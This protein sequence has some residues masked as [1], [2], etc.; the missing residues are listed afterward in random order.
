M[1]YLYLGRTDD[2]LRL[3]EIGLQ[4]GYLFS[5]VPFVTAVAA[6][7]DRLGVLNTLARQYEDDPQLVRPLFRVLTDHTFNDRDRQNAVALVKRS[8]NSLTF[9]PSALLVLR[10]YGEIASSPSSPPIW[11]ARDDAWLKSQSRKRL[12][13]SWRIVP[14]LR[15]PQLTSSRSPAE[16][17]GRAITGHASAGGEDE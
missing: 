1:T 12:M 14:S 9:V 13:Q 2:A 15:H 10:A 6:R 5:D 7:G 17:P 4:N 16:L 8:K 3:V 11:W